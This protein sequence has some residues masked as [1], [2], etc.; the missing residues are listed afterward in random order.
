[1]EKVSVNGKNIYIVESHNQVLEAWETCKHL[2]VFSLD[3]HTD[4]KEAFHTYSYW[5]ADSEIK[6]GEQ[7]NFEVRKQELTE[8]KM[9]QYQKKQST[10]KKIN[11]NLRHD[12]HIDFAVKTNMVNTA[13]ILSKNK[14]PRS[15]NPRVYLADGPEPYKNQRIIEYSPS[16]IPSCPKESHDEMCHRIRADYSLEDLVLQD[17]IDQ[18]KFLIPS[19]FDNFILDIDCD[20]FNTKKSLYPEDFTCFKSLIRQSEFITIALEPE[21]VKICRLRDSNLTSKI[22]LEGLI[23]L[24]QDA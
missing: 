24:I 6:S 19:F 20:Y 5:R 7:R 16:C 10:I 14:N 8:M 15:S 22:I 12:E 21:C 4:T 11:N 2:N 18:A 9:S 17:A 3:Y 23:S 13:F 1:M